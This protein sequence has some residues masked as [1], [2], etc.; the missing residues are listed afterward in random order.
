MGGVFVGDYCEWECRFETQVQVTAAQR[1]E[2]A[3]VWSEEDAWDC[4]GDEG[5]GC[6]SENAEH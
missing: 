5:C 3:D 6:Q 4:K 2:V 1:E